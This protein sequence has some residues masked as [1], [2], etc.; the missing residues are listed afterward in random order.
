VLGTVQEGG[1]GV[2]YDLGPL[3]GVARPEL[4][5]DPAPPAAGS[6]ADGDA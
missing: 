4:D 6:S 5:P 3:P 2:I 1:S